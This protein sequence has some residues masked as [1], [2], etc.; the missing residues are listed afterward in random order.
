ML[1]RLSVFPA[2]WTL[3]AAEAV[4]AD[5]AEAEATGGDGTGRDTAPSDVLGTLSALIAA[6]LVGVDDES[7]VDPRF[8]MLSTVREYAGE[9]LAESGQSAST[10]HRMAEYLRDLTT[11]LDPE[12]YGRGSRLAYARLDAELDNVREALRWAVAADDAESAASVLVALGL[13]WL[14]RGL[15]PPMLALADQVA[16]LPSARGLSPELDGWLTWQRG[17]GRIWLGQLEQAEGLLRDV[18]ARAPTVRDERL[19]TRAQVALGLA[20]PYETEATAARALVDAAVAG[21]RRSR[22]LFGTTFALTYRGLMAMRDG[23]LAGATGDAHRG[24]DPG[25][26]ARPRL[27]PNASPQPGRPGRAAR[28]GRGGRSAVLR[29]QRRALAERRP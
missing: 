3:E 9:R 22:D 6:S 14:A 27:P 20:L 26:A 15:I 17:M 12:L 11:R 1:A 28:R 19:L 5:P 24:A 7:H 4:A 10:R 16:A 23:D 2:S 25:R 13:Y 8:R 29:S 21:S 18:I